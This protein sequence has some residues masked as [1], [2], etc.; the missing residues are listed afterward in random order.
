VASAVLESAP[1]LN[2]GR[3]GSS[4]PRQYVTTNC[5]WCTV[6]NFGRP[7]ARAHRG[8]PA[9]HVRREP[10][11]PRH[12]RHCAQRDCGVSALRR[13]ASGSASGVATLRTIAF[14]VAPWGCSRAVASAHRPGPPAVSW[15]GRGTRRSRPR[16]SM[17][18]C[19]PVDPVPVLRGAR[20]T[21]SAAH[22]R[23]GAPPGALALSLMP[24]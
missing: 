12:T 6:V 24:R 7:L 8:W 3:R 23:P 20:W 17:A 9:D 16:H 1:P 18:G 10:G 14:P 4:R 5:A 13:G 21:L 2:A 22:S 15:C 19:D 11:R